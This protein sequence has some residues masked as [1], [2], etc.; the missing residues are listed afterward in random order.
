MKVKRDFLRF[1]SFVIKDGSQVWFW[2][3]KWLGNRTLRYQY[4]Q[5]YNIARK[6]QDTVAKVLCA[7]PP[8]IS[9]RRDLI[10]HKLVLWN[11]L[12]S[13]LS[14]VGLSQEED[15]FRWKLHQSEEFYVKSHYLALIHQDVPNSTERL[16]K[17][18]V[19][20][21][22]KIFCGIFDKVLF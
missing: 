5:L 2:E 16:W 18:K 1:G 13:W 8:N 22:I 9:W 3:D 10:G 4:P 11:N 21:K 19:T 12:L 14:N 20:L 17:L 15:K 6:K 7:Y